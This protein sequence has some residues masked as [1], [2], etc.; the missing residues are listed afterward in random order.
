L[1]VRR[2]VMSDSADREVESVVSVPTIQ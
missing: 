2:E 1:G